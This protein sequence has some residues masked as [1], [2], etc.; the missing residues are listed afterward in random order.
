MRRKN[1]SR[2]LPYALKC[3]A[4]ECADATRIKKNIYALANSTMSRKSQSTN[5]VSGKRKKRPKKKHVEFH[6]LNLT[7]VTLT[8]PL[9]FG[10]AMREP[11]H[12]PRAGDFTESQMCSQS[13]LEFR[14]FW[15][16]D[17]GREWKSPRFFGRYCYAV[18]YVWYLDDF[19]WGLP[20]H[21]VCGDIM[22]R[23]GQSA[24]FICRCFVK[25]QIELNFCYLENMRI[26]RMDIIIKII[27]H[28][29]GMTMMI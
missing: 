2:T 23:P 10:P 14:L 9:E 4:G 26:L 13:D 25:R 19:G 12:L 8:S 21:A 6:I 24:R 3:N 29:Y 11:A 22:P 27:I 20:W 7:W 17:E 1:P 28:K 16:R 18:L 5:K 15:T